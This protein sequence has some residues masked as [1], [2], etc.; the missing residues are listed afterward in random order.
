MR[1]T[2]CIRVHN[3]LTW[4]VTKLTTLKVTARPSISSPNKTNASSDVESWSLSEPHYSKVKRFSMSFSR[5]STAMTILRVLV[6]RTSSD[7]SAC[8]PLST[9]RWTRHSMCLTTCSCTWLLGGS[10]S[11]LERQGI[12]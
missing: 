8:R 5:R 7:H 1:S 9:R 12:D 3:S 10:V 11:G 2:V 4:S 6:S